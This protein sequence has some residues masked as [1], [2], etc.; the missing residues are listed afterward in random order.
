MKIF[1]C[2]FVMLFSVISFNAN[3]DKPKWAGQKA[4]PAIEERTE[5]KDAMISKND[6]KAKDLKDESKDKVKKVKKEKKAKKE[7]A[8]KKK[9]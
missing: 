7:K 3:A 4:A 9:K 2:Y 6:D 1:I 8:S 5:H